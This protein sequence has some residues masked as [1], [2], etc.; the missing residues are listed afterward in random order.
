MGINELLQ[1][2][3]KMKMLRR[4]KNISQKEMASRLSL[5]CSTYSNYENGHREPPLFVIEDFCAE[6]EISATDLLFDNLYEVLSVK[7]EENLIQKYRCLDEYGKEMVDFVLEKEWERCENAAK[8]TGTAAKIAA[9]ESAN[10]LNAA[11]DMSATEE[12]KTAADQLMQDDN[13]WE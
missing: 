12:Q 10:Y 6:L 1:V 5:S 9:L 3:K 11:H 4:E 13:K 7:K 2:G 8:N